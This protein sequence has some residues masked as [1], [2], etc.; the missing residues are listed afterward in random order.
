MTSRTKLFLKVWLTELNSF[1]KYASKNWTVFGSMHQRNWT[2]F[3]IRL[4]ELNFFQIWLKDLNLSFWHDSKF[5]TFFFGEHDSKNWTFFNEYDSIFP[6]KK[7]TQRIETFCMTL[8][9]NFLSKNDSK[10]WFFQKYDPTELQLFFEIMTQR[11]EF[12]ECDSKNWTF[13]NY[14]SQNWTVFFVTQRIELFCCVLLKELNFFWM[15]QRIEPFVIYQKYLK[16]LNLLLHD[17][18]NWT[19]F[20]EN[21]SQN[22]TFFFLN[23]THRIEPF[24]FEYGP[25]N[26]TLSWI[27]RKELNRLIFEY[28]SKNWTLFA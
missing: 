14:N 2:F 13:W 28:D 8:E 26:W 15:T 25:K 22:W 1:W 16:E 18:K 4:K 5:W 20:F 24:F 27:W 7:L 21:D 17:S 19:F 9:L 12:L 3:L 23:T 10:C 11:I 6:K